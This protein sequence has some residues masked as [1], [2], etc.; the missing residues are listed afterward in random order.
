MV[1]VVIALGVLG[2]AYASAL[3][4]MVVQRSWSDRQLGAGSR[5]AMRLVMVLVVV[6]VA[7]VLALLVA[8]AHAIQRQHESQ[9]K[10][11]SADIV[12]L[13]RT[14]RLYGPD[15]QAVRQG[16][17]EVARRTHE[18]MWPPT[19]RPVPLGMPATQ[20]ATQDVIQQLAALPAATDRQRLL[21]GRALHHADAIAKSHLLISA[22][23]V[24][25]IPW[26]FLAVLTLWISVLF[27]GFGLIARFSAGVAAALFMGAF[28]VAGAIFLILDMSE[29]Y[30]GFL[31]ISDE[32]LRGAIADVRR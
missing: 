11:L 18:A 25:P 23:L 12:L 5:E 26:A 31:R 27:F 7:L 20:N 9:L 29:P 10:E 30:G 14:L 13:D 24:T 19:G 15:A 17:H 28:S 2:C 8:S 6:T 32:P 22:G 16:M 1:A 3:L 21:Q 4:G